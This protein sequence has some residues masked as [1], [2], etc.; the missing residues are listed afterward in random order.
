MVKD[1][2]T[3][4]AII[5]K[6]HKGYNRVTEYPNVFLF[7]TESEVEELGGADA[8][9][10]VLK[11]TGEILSMPQLVMKNMLNDNLITYE[12]EI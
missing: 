6:V 1:R 8:P 4:K 3:A 5:E 10:G 11:A 2:V 7:W 12:G 9:K